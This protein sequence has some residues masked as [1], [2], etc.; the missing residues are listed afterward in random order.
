MLYAVRSIGSNIRRLRERKGFKTQAAFAK[1]LDVPQPRLSDWENDRSAVLELPN[2]LK[3]AKALDVSVDVLLLGWDEQYDALIARDLVRH[4]GEVEK[5]GN[6]RQAGAVSLDTP[7][8]QT[9]EAIRAGS[10]T[11][12]AP[13][14]LLDLLLDAAETLRGIRDTATEQYDRVSALLDQHGF[15]ETQRQDPVASP[16]AP[17]DAEGVR[18]RHRPHAGARRRKRKAG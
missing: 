6:K 5:D 11:P 9:P 2:L 14:A 17:A 15:G 13:G 12:T 1:H 3:I 10:S 16:H 8:P 7:Q 18:G 4:S